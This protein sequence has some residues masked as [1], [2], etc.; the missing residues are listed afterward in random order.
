MS[1]RDCSSIAKFWPSPIAFPWRSS[2]FSPTVTW[3]PCASWRL[4]DLDLEDLA[5]LLAVVEARGE[6]VVDRDAGRGAPRLFLGRGRGGGGRLPEPLEL[7]E[8]VDVRADLDVAHFLGRRPSRAPARS[9]SANET[10]PI[11]ASGAAAAPG[12]AACSGS[13][14]SSESSACSNSWTVSDVAAVERPGRLI[15]LVRQRG[16]GRL[17][18][19]GAGLDL[20]RVLDLGGRRRDDGAREGGRRRRRRR[21]R[22]DLRRPAR[23][24]PARPLRPPCPAAASRRRACAS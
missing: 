24:L 19:K 18:G 4:R 16:R 9:A 1:L 3:W 17:A 13:G 10:S 2:N 8:D 21:G 5:D 12:G 14:A 11:S 22:R 6:Q 15:E 23:A 7:R 20:E